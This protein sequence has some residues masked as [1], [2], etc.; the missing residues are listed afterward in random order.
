MVVLAVRALVSVWVAG[1]AGGSGAGRI[2]LVE[3]F[4]ECGQGLRLEFDEVIQFLVILGADGNDKFCSGFED[5]I[6][7]VI[8]K[9]CDGVRVICNAI[10]GILRGD[11][12]CGSFGELFHNEW[13]EVGKSLI[14]R[15]FCFPFLDGWVEGACSFYSGPEES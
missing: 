5:E 13:A 10:T 9:R 1:V 15:G 4:L 11:F 6:G 3:E 12:A 14:T 7:S 8:G 2:V